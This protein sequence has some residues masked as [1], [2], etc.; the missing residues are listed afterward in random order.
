MF[1]SA[2]S[3]SARI[4]GLALILALAAVLGLAVGNA[5]NERSD[6]GRTNAGY[7]VG[8]N[9]G[10][11]VPISRTATAAFSI[12]ALDAVRIAR[13]DAAAPIAPSEESDYFQRHPQFQETAAEESD[14]HDRHPQPADSEK[15]KARTQ[16]EPR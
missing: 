3:G 14:Y 10:A 7:P 9:G 1:A 12:D 11:R 4:V 15:P 6:E 8:W 5:L 13:G 16:A 2:A